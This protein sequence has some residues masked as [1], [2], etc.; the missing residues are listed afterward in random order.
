[1]A[2]LLDQL[3]AMENFLECRGRAS[4]LARDR[5]VLQPV[6][7]RLSEDAT[8]V[9]AQSGALAREMAQP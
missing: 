5:L 6:F 8:R 4:L 2:R 1:L 7:A 3:A 9:A